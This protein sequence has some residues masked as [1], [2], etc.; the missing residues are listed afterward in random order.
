MDSLAAMRR[1]PGEVWAQQMNKGSICWAAS[2]EV[3]SVKQAKFC[4]WFASEIASGRTVGVKDNL[5]FSSC[6]HISTSSYHRLYHICS[7]DLE[8]LAGD[9][10]QPEAHEILSAGD[11]DFCKVA[12]GTF[13]EIVT[14]PEQ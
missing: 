10:P 13:F 2:D 7:K 11:R 14:Q 12:A 3:C 9:E 8:E 1:T 5:F 4:R 6:N